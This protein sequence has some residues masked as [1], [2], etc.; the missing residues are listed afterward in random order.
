MK[1]IIVIQAASALFLSSFCSNS[2]AVPVPVFGN[3]YEVTS[4][5]TSQVTPTDFDVS[6][7][8]RQQI[9]ANPSLLL[10]NPRVISENGIVSLTGRY[11]DINQAQQ[12]I[13][14]V[15][16]TPGVKDIDLTNF[17][18]A[19]GLPLPPELVTI[20]KVK[21]QLVNQK[22]FGDTPVG[23]LPVKV[24]SS[25]VVYITGT[26]GSEAQAAQVI[27]IAKTTP[28]VVNVEAKITVVSPAQ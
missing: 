25:T 19:N 26:V 12:F 23:S 13:N 24:E 2:S 4:V 27:N 10:V 3:N 1:K 14:L 8:I 7:N 15:I 6:T 11:N 21:L 5:P 22:V 18:S 28:G 9:A 17:V 16:G 20:A